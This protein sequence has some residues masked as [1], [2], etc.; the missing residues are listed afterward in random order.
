MRVEILRDLGACLNPFAAQQLLL[1][2]ETLSLRA[3]RHAQNA[4]QLATWLEAHPQVSWV[5][6]PGLESHPAHAHAKK[7]LK[8]GY[9]GVLSFGISGGGDAGSKVVDGFKLIS[10]LANV[11]DSKTLAIRTWFDCTHA[12]LT[13]HRSLEHDPRAAE[14]AGAH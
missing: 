3:E 11:G 14:R 13:S 4:L 10:N 9:G 1:G 5:S 8:K 7:V 6:Y 12:E 2:I